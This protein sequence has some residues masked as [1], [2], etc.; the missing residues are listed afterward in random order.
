MALVVFIGVM[1]LSGYYVFNHVLEGGEHVTIPNIVGL[2]ITDASLY[3]VEEGLE[4]G[5]IE[6]VPHPTVAAS[7]VISQRPAAGRVVRTGRKVIPTV[8]MGTDFLKAPDLTQKNFQEA[9]QELEQSRFRTGSVARIPHRA[10]RDLVLSQYPPPGAQIGNQDAIHLL[11]SDGLERAQEFMPDIRGLSVAEAEERIAGLGISL[12]AEEVDYPNARR[13]VVLNQDPPADT[14]VY[15]GQVVT[16][17]IRSAEP[18]APAEAPQ[19]EPQQPR[20][21]AEVRHEMPFSWYDQD[22]HVDIID[23]RGNRQTLRRYPPAYDDQSR[24]LRVTGS[25]IRVPL[26]YTGE[27]RV[28]IYVGGELHAA[29]SLR[30]GQA[31]VRTR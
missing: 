20:Y 23:Q 19:P 2:P 24:A 26:S 7:H 3:L 10:E 13:N 6:Q 11:L 30:G 18:E 9:H 27:A 15:Q 29:Y 17:E 12:V 1:A 4:M 22:T 31:P 16:Y 8:S 5:K 21:E 14:L 25:A 28:E